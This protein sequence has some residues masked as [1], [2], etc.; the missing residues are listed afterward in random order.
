M[1]SVRKGRP[2]AENSA[3][4]EEEHPSEGSPERRD[5]GIGGKTEPEMKN[6]SGA[7]R[8]APRAGQRQP[9]EPRRPQEDPRDAFANC[10]LWLN[11]AI[12]SVIGGCHT[13]PNQIAPTRPA[14]QSAHSRPSLPGFL[15]FPLA[16]AWRRWSGVSA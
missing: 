4:A 14:R 2:S 9:G 8:S 11:A 1:I 5:R 12:A 13:L 6:A 16:T 3:P 15:P 7:C 10:H